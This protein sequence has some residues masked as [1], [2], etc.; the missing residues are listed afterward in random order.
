MVVNFHVGMLSGTGRPI[1]VLPGFGVS[2]TTAQV[3]AGLLVA[4]AAL[5][6][7]SFFALM[8]TKVRGDRL[9]KFLIRCVGTSCLFWNCYFAHEFL[10]I[11][12]ASSL[13]AAQSEMKLRAAL[14]VELKAAEVVLYMA[15]SGPVPVGR[16]TLATSEKRGRATLIETAAQDR[17]AARA[18]ARARFDEG[19]HSEL[20]LPSTMLNW[21]FA[22]FLSFVSAIGPT[23]FCRS[24][25][26]AISPQPRRESTDDLQGS[27]NARADAKP[28]NCRPDGIVTVDLMNAAHVDRVLTQP[29]DGPK[30]TE[31]RLAISNAGIAQILHGVCGI[32]DAFRR[33]AVCSP[34]GEAP[35]RVPCSRR[36]GRLLS[37]MR[38]LNVIAQ[39]APKF[40]STL[41]QMSCRGGHWSRGPPTR[42]IVC[43]LKT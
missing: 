12:Q 37:Q 42:N 19:A 25:A 24:N 34:N 31:E 2:L 4:V 21:A 23:V 36:Q 14:D 30:Q 39:C 26:E 11:D 8:P 32:Y 40:S 35:I 29:F 20:L 5:P 41:L 43:Q 10:L 18:R 17:A 6:P 16:T 3:F 33:F 38:D 28:Q 7:L 13:R 15:R 9:G 22:V 1:F 27:N